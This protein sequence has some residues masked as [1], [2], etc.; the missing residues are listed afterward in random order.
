M[1][2]KVGYSCVAELHLHV[3]FRLQLNSRIYWPTLKLTTKYQ[4]F[5]H[6]WQATCQTIFNVV[7]IAA[8]YQ[9]GV[10]PTGASIPDHLPNLC[11][12]RSTYGCRDMG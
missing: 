6:E 2:I 4:K 8:H 9:Y 12:Y 3:I 11:K 1:A 7:D 10:I 5:S